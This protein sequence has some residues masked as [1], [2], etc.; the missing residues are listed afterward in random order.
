MPNA[1]AFDATT[2]DEL[3]KVNVG[4]GFNAPPMTFEVNAKQYVVI[5]S[6]PSAIGYT[7]PERT[8]SAPGGAADEIRVPPR[9]KNQR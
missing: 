9:R 7:R 8:G 5:A 2:P 1:A 4:T 3:W 6:G